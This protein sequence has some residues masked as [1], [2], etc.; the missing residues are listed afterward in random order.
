MPH[1][2][3]LGPRGWR[4]LNLLIALGI[5]LAL[6]NPGNATELAIPDNPPIAS[7]IE[8]S[9]PDASG[10]VTVTGQPGAVPPNS[11]VMVV[12]LDTGH[13]EHSQA[14]G[15]G[16]FSLSTFAP[17]GTSILIKGDPSGAVLERVLDEIFRSGG[18]GNMAPLAGTIL[19]VEDPPATGP[20]VPF[21][22]AGAVGEAATCSDPS[23]PSWIFQGTIS[24]QE[25][26]PGETFRLRGLLSIT[27]P[28]LQEAGEMRVNG[29]LTLIRLSRADGVADLPQNTFASVLLTP[30]GFPIERRPQ[31]KV[32]LEGFELP[33]TK[34]VSNRAEAVY[35]RSVTLLADLPPG[36]YRPV[37]SFFFEGVPAECPPTR[38][39][40]L[41]DKP[42]I[43]ADNT[44]YLPVVRV[45]NPAAPRVFSAL[46]TDTLSNGTRGVGAGED[47]GRFGV[48]ARIL[49]QSETFIV[50]RL[51]SASGEPLTYRLEPFAPTLSRGDRGIPPTPPLIPFRF[52]SGRLTVQVQKPDGSVDV[53]GPASFVQARVKTLVDRN[54]ETLDRGGGHLTD[55]Y[56]LST[57][58]PSFEFQFT[59]DGR[60]LI[61]LDGSIEDIWGTAW[62]AGGA[63]E[64]Y[65]ARPLSLDTAVLPMTSFEVGDVFAPGLLLTPPV[66]ALVDVRF[67]L[68]PNS[69]P[70]RTIEWRVSGQANRFG[71]FNPDSGGIP[72]EFPGEYRVDVTASFRDKQENLW[73]GSR[74][75]GGVVAAGNPTIIA[76][77]RRG[78]DNQP[79]TGPQW[80]FLS[81]LPAGHINFPFQTGDITWQ[82]KEESALPVLTF[83]DLSG[84]LISLLRPHSFDAG[85]DGSTRFEERAAVGETPL[86]S[87]GRAQSTADVH[88]DPSNL[89]FWGYGYMSVQRPLVR[90]REE[91]AEDAIASAYWRFDEQYA[92]QI[93]MGPN[94]D[95]K[96]DIKFQ[97]GG[98]VLRGPA[99]GEAQYA[100]YGS[101]F[102][103]LPDDDP[104]GGTRTFPPFQGNGGGP[105][106]GPIMTLK[107]REV[108]L[109]IHLTGVRPGTILEVG[110]TFALTGAVGSTLP[111]FVAY[112][113]T[114]PSG[115]KLTFSERANKIGYYY[116]PEPRIS[117]L[118]L[119]RPQYTS[120]PARMPRLFALTV[121]AQ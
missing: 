87:S 92:C 65:A 17:A 38:P 76:H 36:Y 19:R 97:Y 68:L 93:G 21:G 47:R 104:L 57:M 54:G 80:F 7:L 90:V 16:S 73:M 18:E 43:H 55:V 120:A 51:N 60:H 49:T 13:F 67:R 105:S 41:V 108:D 111:A 64:V 116:H 69:D 70:G 10:D 14:A 30:T 96:N 103:L 79:D 39:I 101:L 25:L 1:T 107:G 45:G 44:M 100:I 2:Y 62:S 40:L 106:G 35:D 74:T 95:L 33:L 94:G 34:V 5:S 115:Q 32:F 53:L 112:A 102:V 46:L 24:S 78:I 20:E 84:R 8:V 85:H 11:F 71:Y 72:L 4:D 28:A 81:T 110:D 59:Q 50:P 63:Y 29:E 15:D 61:T 31:T 88:L 22:G 86:F 12:T 52:P 6:P 121:N 89:D 83:Q 37:L 98:A 48:A 9:D 56:Q 42:G 99:I 118:A 3:S 26:A 27:S 113:I 117:V 23:L 58:D 114:K 66:A 77:G 119:A 109:F 91:I 82:Q 75:W